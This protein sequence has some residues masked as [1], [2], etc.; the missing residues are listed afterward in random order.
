M[1]QVVRSPNDSDV[2]R[3]VREEVREMCRAFPLYR[4]LAVEE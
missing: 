3:A 2:L 1:S 4:E